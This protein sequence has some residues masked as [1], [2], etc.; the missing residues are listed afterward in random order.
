MPVLSRR[1][2]SFALVLFFLLS[3]PSLVAAQGKAADYERANNLRDRLQGLAVNVPERANWVGETSRFWY[4]KSVKG[5]ISFVLVDAATLEKKPAFDHEKLAAALAAASG[6][7]FTAVTLPFPSISFVDKERA[8]EFA[9]AGSLWRCDLGSYE[10][11]KTGPAPTGFRGGRAPDASD[12]SPRE[13]E[14]DVFDGMAEL[15]PRLKCPPSSGRVFR[16]P[17]RG[18]PPKG[19]G[20]RPLPTANGTP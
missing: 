4:R 16:S 6:E 2:M 20:R 11:K 12:D 15:P 17:A 19:P 7:K 14:N 13:F 1:L 10:C 5:G 3:L 9:A 18:R 8:L